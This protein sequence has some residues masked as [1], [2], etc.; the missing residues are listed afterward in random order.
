MDPVDIVTNGSKKF[1]CINGVAVLLGQAQIS[2][3]EGHVTTNTLYSA[4]AFL[5]QLFSLINKRNVDA[6]IVYSN[7]WKKLLNILL[8]Y[9]KHF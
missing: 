2:W 3:L 7:N 8:Q 6:Y 5:E 4:L 9:I 1:V